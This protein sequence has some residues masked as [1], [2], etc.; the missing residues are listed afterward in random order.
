MPANGRDLYID[1]ML[2]NMA[3]GYRPEGM[4]ADMIAPIAQVP[5]QSGYFPIFSRADRLRVEDTRRAPGTRA[6]QIQESVGSGTFFCTN[7]ALGSPVTLEDRAN[8]DPIMLQ[9][10]INGKTQLVLDKL[11]LDWEVR[12][13][14]Q[15]TSGSNVGSYSAT[16]SGWNDY[17]NA[18]PLG[19]VQTAI[20]NIQDTTGK[21][22]NRVTFGRNAWDSFRRNTSIRDIV[23][24]TNNGGG[25]VNRAQAAALLEVDEVLVG[26]AYQNT[27][28][29]GLAESLDQIWD[30]NVLVSYSPMTAQREVPAFMYTFRW[31]AAGLPQLQVERHPYDSRTK[32]EDI[33]AGYYQ[34]E[35]IVGDEYGFLLVGVNSSQ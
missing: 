32:S 31:A 27:G 23:H 35:K 24:G 28:A 34:D 8:A 10:I 6:N 19:D 3:L 22:P 14:S 15:V 30:D 13:A 4:I 7:Y 18:D 9:G 21:H 12:V 17:T 33:E 20:K 5:Q 25:Y 11:F 2:S 29:E 1:K 16:G 26:D